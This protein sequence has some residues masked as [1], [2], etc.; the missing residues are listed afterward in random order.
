MQNKLYGIFTANQANSV[1]FLTVFLKQLDEGWGLDD[2]VH[3]ICQKTWAETDRLHNILNQC[4]LSRRVAH[5]AHGWLWMVW[6]YW[7]C[8]CHHAG[9]K[10]PTG[11]TG[12][13]GWTGAL[14][15]TG[16]RGPRGRQGAKGTPGLRDDGPVQTGLRGVPGARG[17]PGYVGPPGWVSFW[18]RIMCTTTTRQNCEP[19]VHSITLVS[20][21]VSV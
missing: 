8:R 21:A 4:S 18:Y 16:P 15:P 17:V 12:A 9:P 11:A 10:G 13:T 14:G 7:L 3:G 6:Y 19:I 20:E 1:L 5:F 2:I